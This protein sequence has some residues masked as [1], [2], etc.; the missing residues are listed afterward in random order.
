MHRA[1]LILRT[2]LQLALIC[3]ATNVAAIVIITPPPSD[4]PPTATCTQVS[5]TLVSTGSTITFDAS[6]TDPDINQSFAAVIDWDDGTTSAGTV[7]TTGMGAYSVTGS[8]VY[9]LPGVYSIAMTVS[10][11][12]LVGGCLSEYVVVYDPD[13]GFVTG[14]GWF[15]SPPGAYRA[16]PGVT[17]RANFGFVSKYLKGAT[18]PVGSTEFN[19]QTA[20]LNF[21]SHSYEWLVVAGA[22]AIYKGWGTINEQGN[23]SFMLTAIDGQSPGGGGSDRIRIQIWDATGIVYDNQSGEV[24]DADPTQAISGSIVI[25]K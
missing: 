13:A 4:T 2:A 3:I 8:H 11:G 17:G 25:H 23:Y 14:G 9:A 10:D 15:N 16:D 6:F 7:S 22:K 1:I 24:F 21:H 5:S 19:F 12:Q 20:R 18:V